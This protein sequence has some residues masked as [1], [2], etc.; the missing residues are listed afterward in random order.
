MPEFTPTPLFRKSSYSSQSQNCVEVA[1][2]EGG[3]GAV[4]DTKNREA[5]ALAFAP[6]EWRAALLG[7]K[8][9]DI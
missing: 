3:A 1:D 4:R 5:G 7:I 6:E 8:A 2:L 9:G